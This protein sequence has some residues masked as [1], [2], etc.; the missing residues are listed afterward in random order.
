MKMVH[1]LFGFALVLVGIFAIQPASAGSAV[2][3]GPH[4]QGVHSY[5]QP[6]ERDK[7][8]SARPRAT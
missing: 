3:L 2:A 8:T 4:N 7:A 6:M 5:G 1:S